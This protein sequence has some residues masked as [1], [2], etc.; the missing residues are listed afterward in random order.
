MKKII[1]GL[2]ALIGSATNLNAQVKIDE[3]PSSIIE[4]KNLENSTN[5]YLQNEVGF[6]K[7]DIFETKEND[8]KLIFERNILV[9]NSNEVII[10]NFGID[11]K[12]KCKK[13][14][15]TLNPGSEQQTVFILRND[16]NLKTG[17]NFLRVQYGNE[18][19]I[20]RLFHISE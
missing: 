11:G 20:Y 1:V 18:I 19:F 4:D 5:S 7:F 3:K 10:E 15:T 9:N 17:T 16:L 14:K 6:N 8:L 12:V 13:I 2:I